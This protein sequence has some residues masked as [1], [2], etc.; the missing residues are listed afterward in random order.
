MSYEIKR[1]LEY[2]INQGED[3]LQ[4]L[5]QAKLEQK[6]IQKELK[7]SF[8]TEGARIIATELLESVPGGYLAKKLTKAYLDQQQKE[9]MAVIE[10]NFDRQLMSWLEN[11][12]SFLST[13]SIWK[14][15]LKE[16]NSHQLTGRLEKVLEYVKP[17]T[18]IKR[19][20]INL[21]GFSNKLLI[22]NKDIPKKSTKIEVV[23]EI[24]L[25]P[26]SPYTGFRKIEGLLNE[27][28]GYIKIID[29]YVDEET[30][31]ILL[32]TP[33]SIPIL[34]LAAYTGGKKKGKRFIRLCQR[35]KAEKPNF[36]IR[37]CGPKVIHDRFILTQR[38]G[39]N[40]GT[41]LKDIGK[42][43]SSITRLSD[44]LRTKAEKVF[45]DLWNHSESL[46]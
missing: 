16:P 8:F 1:S 2:F 35:F 43:L 19:A 24:L 33:K 9:Q 37:K 36:E 3:L 14:R 22:Y 38:K 34:L 13:I 15:N 18:K 29:P 10:S 17:E 41:S 42:R 27:A 31:D 20:I 7:K 32:S 21:R 45:D 6:G 11:M 28:S 30:L 25:P 39:W 26:G 23:D 5:E 44:T 46:V 4:R 12:K 40:V